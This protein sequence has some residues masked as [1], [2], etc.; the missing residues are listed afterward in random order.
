MLGEMLGIIIMIGAPALFAVAVL[1]W[2]DSYNMKGG[3]K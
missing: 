3:K 2:A 1:K